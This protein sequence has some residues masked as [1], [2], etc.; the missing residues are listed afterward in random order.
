[1]RANLLMCAAMTERSTKGEPLQPLVERVGIPV[2][3]LARKAGVSRTATTKYVRIGGSGEEYDRVAAALKEIAAASGTG[4]DDA[5]AFSVL[6]RGIVVQGE[7]LNVREA[8]RYIDGAASE[9][10]R[11]RRIALVEL[12]QQA[13]DSAKNR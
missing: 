13:R 7:A 2:A 12:M 5:A 11:E 9:E 1:M 6:H 8:I 4:A 10:E 3:K